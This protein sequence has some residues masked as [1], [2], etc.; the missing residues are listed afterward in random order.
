MM[1]RLPAIALGRV[2]ASQPRRTLRPLVG[3]LISAPSPSRANRCSTQLGQ[4][5]VD[6]ASSAPA[7]AERKRN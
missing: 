2:C 7:E 4:V 6:M 5:G 3:E 1:R